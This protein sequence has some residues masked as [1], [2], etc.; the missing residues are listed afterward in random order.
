MGS[1]TDPPSD[2]SPVPGSGD[3]TRVPAT[4]Q[5]QVPPT[6]ETTPPAAGDGSRRSDRDLILAA[7]QNAE[8]RTPIGLNVGPGGSGLPP[9]RFDDDLPRDFIPGYELIK[10]IHRGGQGVVYQ[11]LQLTT[12]RRVAIKVMHDNRFAGSSGRARFEREVQILGQ[13]NHPNIVRIHDSGLTPGAAGVFYYVMDYVSGRSLEDFIQGAPPGGS[14]A[15]KSVKNAATSAPP[16]AD[17]IKLFTKICEAVNAAHLKGVIHR[18]LKPSNIRINT[19]GEPIILD[20]G[21]AKVAM[22]DVDE[23]GSPQLMTVTGQFIGSLPWASP[24]QAE[25]AP[26]GIDL[27]TDVYSLGVILFQM[28]TGGK[29]PYQVIGAMRDVLDNILRAEPARPSTMRRQINDEIETI[30]LKCLAKP[31]ERRYQSAGELAR[32][33]RRYLNGQPIEAKRDSVGYMVG[34]TLRRYRIPA[35]VAAAFLLLLIGFAIAM[36]YA[37]RREAA[38][39]TRADASAAAATLAR[40][41]EKSQR[42]RA[43]KNFDVAR[44]LWRTFMYDFNDEIRTLRGT[45]RAREIIL[46]K[47]LAAVDSLKAQASDDPALLRELADAHERV[48]DL[49]GALF[50]PRLGETDQA[51]ADYAAA[52]QIR[53][54]LLA[55][56]P[57]DARCH[58]DMARSLRRDATIAIA[59]RDYERADESL[60]LARERAE[61]ARTLAP[62][63]DTRLRTTL[64]RLLAEIITAR[65]DTAFFIAEKMQDADATRAQLA[66]A[67]ALYDE[68]GT[69]VSAG[70]TADEASPAKDPKARADADALAGMLSTIA[71]NKASNR[72][73]MGQRLAGSSNS[74]PEAERA[75]GA[76]RDARLSRVTLA[77]TEFD[78]ATTIA[79][80]ALI[81]FERRSAAA[82][83]NGQLRRDIMLAHHTLG[84]IQMRTAQAQRVAIRLG[85]PRDAERLAAH[86]RSLDHNLKALQIARALAAA[87]EANL[88]ARRDLA[89]CLNKTGNELRDLDREREALAVFDESLR[90][91]R[92]TISTDP[93]Q[94]HRN[95]LGVGLFKA[96][97]VRAILADDAA[98]TPDERKR[99]LIEARALLAE[100][101]TVFGSLRDDK[102]MAADA[103]ELRRCAQVL[104]ETEDK[105]T[106]LGNPAP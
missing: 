91:R 81:D 90:V 86:Q 105:I 70:L 60:R 23:R 14:S 79:A 44:G 19:E 69:L 38:Q 13:L 29:F 22:P 45:T 31:R 88:E 28:L 32:D 5:E 9:F 1:P 11:A 52:K 73:L 97:E 87:D 72:L 49:R 62:E 35:A 66:K 74:I 85:E 51:A 50:M 48:G 37:Y 80:A 33:L 36:T 102:V 61:H 78:R 89:I 30:V 76:A 39:R 41:E 53:D 42:E 6:S 18:D 103:V 3:A 40:D 92:E 58:A 101:M 25:G 77:L 34:K 95:D 43:E 24:E 98:T 55:K 93:I 56:S 10:Q 54:A 12:K 68:A 96:G 71:D 100:S 64:T 16:I 7:I 57:N 67:D 75:P 15:E 99:L 94:R 27:R 46:T 84:T 4:P 63:S 106:A 17:A 104:K 26:G 2:P 47:A 82:P 59:A 8:P 83:E 20:F 65:G 21:L